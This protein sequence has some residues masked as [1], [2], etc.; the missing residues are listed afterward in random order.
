MWHP[1]TADTLW[2]GFGLIAQAVFAMRFLWQWIV[3]ER[4][5]ESV[6]PVGFWYFSLVGGI[7]LTVYAVFRDPVL[8]PGQA[9]GLVIYVRNLILIHRTQTNAGFSDDQHPTPARDASVQR[10]AA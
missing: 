9:A 10:R 2:A 5:K 7:M 8:I 4:R 3:S 6:I 1:S